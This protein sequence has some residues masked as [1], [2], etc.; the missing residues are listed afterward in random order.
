MVPARGQSVV[1]AR[2]LGAA[3]FVVAVVVW[4][5]FGKAVGPVERE[6]WS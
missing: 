1:I 3:V 6:G 5:V 2:A 4:I